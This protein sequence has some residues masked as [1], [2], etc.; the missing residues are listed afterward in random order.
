MCSDSFPNAIQSLGVTCAAN[1]S[2]QPAHL[3]SGRAHLGN[4]LE[5]GE[6]LGAGE[7]LEEAHS[8]LTVLTGFGNQ[9]QVA[10]LLSMQ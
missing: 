2:R 1:D 3:P 6:D 5:R 7:R 4:I 10:I 9:A 8:P